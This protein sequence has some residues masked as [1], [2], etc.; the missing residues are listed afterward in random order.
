MFRMIGEVVARIGVGEN[1]EASAIER[2]PL[3][4]LAELSGRD[5]QLA[6]SARMGADGPLMEVADRD[7][8]PLLGLVR[9]VPG[10]R[11]LGRVE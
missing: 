1:G 11:D 7:A 2:R 9:E 3:G 10:G 8:E 4:K 6:A 5:R